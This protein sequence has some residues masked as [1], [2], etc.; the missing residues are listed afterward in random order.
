METPHPPQ[1][2]IPWVCFNWMNFRSGLPSLLSHCPA[3]FCT[4]AGQAEP[5]WCPAPWE[6]GVPSTAAPLTPRNFWGPAGEIWG[7]TRTSGQGS[8]V[9]AATVPLWPQGVGDRDKDK[10][11]PGPS[12]AHVLLLQPLAVASPWQAGIPG[13]AAA[14]ENRLLS[15]SGNYFIRLR[16]TLGRAGHE[17]ELRPRSPP[18]R[19]VCNRQGDEAVGQSWDLERV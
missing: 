18:L 14:N 11:V 13:K 12:W 15:L 2:L 19:L 10:D 3:T 17:L 6:W 8:E 5:D 9:L 7:S 16:H 4:P 1:Q